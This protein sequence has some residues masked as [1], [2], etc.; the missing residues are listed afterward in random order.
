MKTVFALALAAGLLA[1][2]AAASTQQAGQR[3]P[4]TANIFGAGYT[5]A[6][7]P[8]G[9]GGGTLPP[10]WR[11]PQ[12]SSRVVTFPLI[13]GKVTPIV[14]SAPTN[15]AEGDGLGPTDV[16]SWRGISG[17]VDA[18]NGMFLVGVFLSDGEPSMP[19]PPRLDFTN[20]ERF[21][22]LAPRLG[23]T[24]FIGDGQGR[25]YEVPE[26]ATRLFVGFAD[27]AL[28][29]GLPGW[30]GNNAGSL[31]VDVTGTLDVPAADTIPPTLSGAKHKTLRAPRGAKRLRV[32]YI[33]TAQ[34]A[35][36]GSVPVA[37]T[38]RSGS[39]FSLG[40]TKVACSATDS[41]GNTGK[42]QFMVTVKRA[43]V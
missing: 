17:T 18:K 14:D 13:T 34:D 32:R 20:K 22:R 36:D 25:S 8:G 4:A 15:G 5:I 21:D 41:S 33:V 27:G 30:Y 3:V 10:V 16:D 7:A 40:R 26:A 42:A 39:Y 12:G 28:Y 9:G 35:V 11:L 38:P 19:P 31:A 24:F 1:T 29:Q 2:A 37:C 43:R 23:Q 6:P